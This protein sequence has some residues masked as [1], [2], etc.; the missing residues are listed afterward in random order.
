MFRRVA[1]D[2]HTVE[3]LDF[4]CS[5]LEFRNEAEDALVKSSCVASDEMR[6]VFYIYGYLY[7]FKY[8]SYKSMQ[9]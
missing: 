3:N 2:K 9:I 6:F 1:E 8:R 4:I 7:L 5:I